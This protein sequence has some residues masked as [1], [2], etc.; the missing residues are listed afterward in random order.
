M[1]APP[2]PRRRVARHRTD[3]LVAAAVLCLAAPVLQ[4]L[5]AQQSSRYALTA[6][7][8]DRGTVR[9]DAYEH[10]L[11][12]DWA[13]SD[14]HVYSDKAPVQPVLAV[15]AYA[16][17]RALGGEPADRLRIDGNLGLWT[18]SLATSAVPAAALAVLMRRLARRVAPDPAATAAAL[19]VAFGTLLLPFATVLFGHVL[20][21]TFGTA[22]ALLVLRERPSPRAVAAAGLLTGLGV[23]TEYTVAI[24]ALVLTGLVA[25]RHTRR[26]GWWVLGGL[27]PAAALVGYQWAVFGSPLS[28]SYEH[29]R[30]TGQHAGIGGVRLLDP[31]RLADVLAGDRGLFLATP[32]VLLGVAGSL[33]L[34]RRAAGRPATHRVV[35]V[36]GLVAFAGF[37]L[38]QAGWGNSTGGDSPGARYVTPALPLLAAGVAV[39]LA[40]WPLVARWMVGVSVAVMGLA[41]VTQPLMGRD[42]PNAVAGW[43]RLA[44]LGRWTATVPGLV[45]GDWALVAVV[46]GA[47][48]LAVAALRSAGATVV[49]PLGVDGPAGSPAPDGRLPAA[50]AG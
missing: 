38:V 22:A 21:A 13:A 11:G 27:G 2:A 5:M 39:G 31:D 29:S 28:F 45:L 12:M 17:Y 6:A 30:G 9:I 35:G 43:L 23:A 20:A 1:T 10:T 34:A 47:G 49:G 44:G 7:L 48:V 8:W 46:A 42:V 24:L 36:V 3:L 37:L 19:A 18:V 14:G 40:R 33:A 32:V 15:P 50:V 25:V 26:L 4:V 41:T 16:A